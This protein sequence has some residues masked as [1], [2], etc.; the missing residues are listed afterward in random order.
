MHFR[1]VLVIHR[2][3]RQGIVPDTLN[4]EAQRRLFDLAHDIGATISSGSVGKRFR[5]CFG[6]LPRLNEFI[7]AP[8]NRCPIRPC[9]GGNP[10]FAVIADE[11][12]QCS[13]VSP[14][15]FFSKSFRVT[16][17]KTAEIRIDSRIGIFV[18]FV[19]CQQLPVKPEC[20]HRNRILIRG[21]NF[22]CQKL[23]KRIENRSINR[24]AKRILR[25]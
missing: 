1:Q 18:I 11:T 16:E 20:F 21:V 17:F 10:V 19:K 15:L 2:D 5:T 7:F 24:E 13:F 14:V 9:S 25:F 22:P 6:N 3:F 4:G 12:F 23:I 8:Q